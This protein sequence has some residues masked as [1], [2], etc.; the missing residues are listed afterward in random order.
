MPTSDT[1]SLARN[2]YQRFLESSDQVAFL[3]GLVSLNP[4]TFETEWLEFKPYPYQKPD[5]PIK[6]IWSKNISAFGNTQD[7]VLIWGISAKNFN[8][9][10]AAHN[11]QLVPNP[12]ELRTRLFELHHQATNPP[13]SGI[14]IHSVIDPNESGKGFV[15]CF[16]PEGK[17]VPYRGSIP[18]RIIMSG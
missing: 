14:K 1:P 9:V 2:F 7:G 10:D 8:R 11:F 4:H 6:E 16:I 17:F 15:V 3:R 5:E 13:L 18:V 12:D